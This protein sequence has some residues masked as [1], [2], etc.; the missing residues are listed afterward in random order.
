MASGA[1]LAF[2]SDLEEK[3]NAK[4]NELVETEETLKKYVGPLVGNDVASRP[5]FR[6]RLGPPPQRENNPRMSLDGGQRRTSGRGRFSLEGRLGP[7]VNDDDDID[8][9]VENN[10]KLMS[11][12]VV[13]QKSREEA[14]AEKKV[15]ITEA[16]VGFLLPKRFAFI[17]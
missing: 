14:L 2:R 12:V 13:E 3:L 16:Q 6:G 1:V 11:R 5:S 4:K 7:K 15:D 8:D 9:S 17:D 10:R